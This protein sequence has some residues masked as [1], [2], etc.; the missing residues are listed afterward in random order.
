MRYSQLVSQVR[1]AGGVPFVKTNVPKLSSRSSVPTPSLAGVR[2]RTAP[3]T[4]AVALPEGKQ[5][6]SRVMDLPLASDLTSVAGMSVPLCVLR[7]V[8]TGQ[9]CKSD[10]R[11]VD[12]SDPPSLRIPAGSCGIY[13]FKPGH[14]RFGSSTGIWTNV[15][16]F[17]GLKTCTGPMG[18]SIDDLELACRLVFG[19]ASQLYEWLPPIPY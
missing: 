19:K 10:V 14:A 11:A 9:Y 6:C 18:R 7:C 17:E 15:P 4:P 5:R 3:T 12:P 13:S 8:G 2:T 16:G 1:D